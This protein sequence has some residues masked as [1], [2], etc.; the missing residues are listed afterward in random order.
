MGVWPSW[1]YTI[2]GAAVPLSRGYAPTAHRCQGRFPAAQRPGLEEASW[3]F[4]QRPLVY[5]QD[6]KELVLLRA[7]LQN[8]ITEVVKTPTFKELTA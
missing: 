8:A 1:S 3:A 4:Q 2:L 6:P 5:R 7:A